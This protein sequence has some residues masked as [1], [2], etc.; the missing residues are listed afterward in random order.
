MGSIYTKS[1]GKAFK[2]YPTK[3]SRICEWLGLKKFAS[4]ELKWILRDINISVKPGEAVG[5]IGMNGA[6]KS[7]LLKL[8]TGTMLPTIGDVQVSGK[9]AALLELG[10]G[11]HPDFTGRQNVFLAG[12]LL[13]L[14]GE[15]IERL[16][17]EI[18]AFAEIGEYI[19]FPV[20]VY[21]SGMQVRLAFSVATAVRPDILI[22]DEALS[23]GDVL[24]QQKCI[25]RIEEYR[26]KGTTLLFVTHDTAALHLLC[27]WAVVLGGGK[28]IYQGQT[29][30]AIE[31]YLELLGALKDGVTEDTLADKADEFSK[32]AENSHTI[33]HFAQLD[34]HVKDVKFLD[35]DGQDIQM[36]NE[37]SDFYIKFVLVGLSKYKDPHV[38]FRIQD[39]LGSVMYETN[40][41]CQQFSLQKEFEKNPDRLSLIVK[42]KNN[43]MQGEYSIAIGI[44]QEGY[45]MGLFKKV[46]CPTKVYKT[47]TVVRGSTVKMWGGHSNL[48]PQFT[49]S[50]SDSE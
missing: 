25:T 18:E 1:L 9:V 13:G 50:G 6:G 2:R 7:T 44:E 31:I 12:Q 39:R 35:G 17:P 11:F 22:V 43:L 8:I 46:I 3:W 27:D 32:I 48:H 47:F 19:D 41:F 26:Q 15:H 5:I 45:G 33:G 49:C 24:F 38:G 42:C 23:V 28:C 36:L 20:R 29:K 37:E 40:T 34:E 14:N 16:M 10:L 4:Q 30:Q 21:S